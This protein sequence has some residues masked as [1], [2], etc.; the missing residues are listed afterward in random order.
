MMEQGIM[1][2]RSTFQVW[3]PAAIA[4]EAA[5]AVAQWHAAKPGVASSLWLSTPSGL[6]RY[7]E[8]ILTAHTSSVFGD[9]S[10]AAR[11]LRRRLMQR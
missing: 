2:R 4:E 9:V 7:V 3:P 5:P 1:L 6:N 8:E 10:R 11:E